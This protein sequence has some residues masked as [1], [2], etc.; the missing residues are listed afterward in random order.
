MG[1]DQHNTDE[2]PAMER[3]CRDLVEE[4]RVPG[5]AGAL[6][7]MAENFGREVARLTVDR[8]V[9]CSRRRWKRRAIQRG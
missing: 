8:T 2:L 5:E 3:L 6:L 1:R 7:K 4:S 9:D